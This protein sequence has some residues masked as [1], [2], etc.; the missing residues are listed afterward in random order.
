MEVV[1]ISPRELWVVAEAGWS[2]PIYVDPLSNDAKTVTHYSIRPAIQMLATPFMELSKR[3]GHI[4]CGTSTTF[5]VIEASLLPGIASRAQG[6][7]AQ[8]YLRWEATEPGP[9]MLGREEVKEGSNDSDAFVNYFCARSSIDRPMGRYVWRAIKDGL[10]NWLINVQRPIDFELFTVHPIPYRVNWKEIMLAKYPASPKIF[11]RQPGF[12][13]NDLLRMGFT[14]D[15]GSVDLIAMN[16]KPRTFSWTLEIEE[17]A[18]LRREWAKAEVARMAVKKPT[19]Y[20]KYYEGTI[21]RRFRDIL[22]IFATYVE[23][24][25]APVA[26]ICEGARSGDLILCPRNRAGRVTTT[27]QR[28]EFVDFQIYDGP[29]LRRGQGDEVKIQS[30]V[31]KMFDLPGVQPRIEDVRGRKKD[32]SL[33]GPTDGGDGTS[34]VPLLP[35]VQVDVEVSGLL[36]GGE[37]QS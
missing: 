30:K 10:L 11:E 35:A 14:Q 1:Q 37:N 18:L 27:N 29:S 17:S 25:S 36:A 12:W 33:D 34:G 9:E 22:S 8:D 13:E 24:A 15:L 26:A 19:K 3:F 20:A 16:K 4:N 6:C 32:R 5:W 2:L 21:K 7:M 28:P 31:L 23:K